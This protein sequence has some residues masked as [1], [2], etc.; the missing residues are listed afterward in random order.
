MSH[1]LNKKKYF[2]PTSINNAA[3]KLLLSSS[4]APF[5]TMHP[6]MSVRDSPSGM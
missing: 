5:M 6:K 1:A 3:Q 2:V 4:S